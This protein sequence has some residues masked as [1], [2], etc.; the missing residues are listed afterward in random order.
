MKLRSYLAALVLAGV[1]PLVVLTVLVTISLARQQRAAVEQGLS[2]TVA[3]LA[4][5]IENEVETSIKSLETLATSKRLDEDDLQ[6]FYEQAARV[7]RLHRW[8]TIGLIDREGRHRLNLARPL[9]EPLPDLRD[10]D[11]FEQVMATGTP[12]VSDLLKGRATA[13]L[14]IAVAV[15]VVRDG[16]IKYVLFAGLDPASFNA[17]LEAQKLPARALASVVSRDG[18]F[19]AR[20]P[21][22]PRFVGHAPVAAYLARIREASD[23]HFRGPDLEGVE[24]EI[25]YRRMP[26]TGW[27]VGFGLPMEALNGP[28][29]RV[30]WTGAILGAAIV[31][32]ALGLAAVFA[33]RMA[34]SIAALASSASALGREEPLTTSARLPVAELD[35]MR[36]FLADADALLRA[37]TR[38][39]AELLAREQAARE[40]AE[41]AS[42]AK[43]QFLAMLGHELRNPLGAIVSAAALLDLV[44]TTDEVSVS[45]RQ[46][47]ARQARHLARL[48]DDLLDVA[49]VTAGKIIL[50]RVPV[51]LAALT[52]RVVTTLT[53][54]SPGRHVVET[55]LAEVWVHAD[56]TRIEQVVANLVGNAFKYTPP[57]ERISITVR[58]DRDEALLEVSD[59]GIGM[60]ADLVPRVF[61]LFVQAHGTPDRAR[62]GLGIGLTLSRHL[63]ALHNG[64][65][66][67]ASPG[68]RMG[69]TFTV[70]LPAV[71]TPDVAR[72]GR[73]A[74]TPSCTRRR[75]Q[76]IEDNA[77][78]RTAL[79]LLL[80]NLGHEVHEAAD[81]P[82]GLD[83]VRKLDPDVVL[84]D[85]GLPGVDG[86]EVARRVRAGGGRQP[87]LVALTGYGLPED[88]QRA[89]EAGFDAHLLKPV[90]PRRLTAIIEGARR[91]D[92]EARRSQ[93][94]T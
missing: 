63:V 35:E 69:S 30:A 92:V 1:L 27:T 78:S 73:I 52:H 62:G 79:S 6:A 88:R 12:Y 54:A 58:R 84:V 20:N 37:R 9:G 85:I 93:G 10:R 3:A 60:S 64:R 22:H 46:V 75:V 90:D 72:E 61:D 32:A 43:D 15:P 34:R 48:V 74:H 44:G 8:S 5:A 24:R 77:D 76:L 59:T 28:V 50:D 17:L 31:M 53:A 39:R 71:A 26:L 49:R 81:G 21:E 82:T 7:R 2:D 70:R 18:V 65:I 56:E 16:R 55:D 57:D 89:I 23:G 33:R 29:R 68:L 45:A 38:E 41:A 86:Y 47:I 94:V 67:A 66:T 91:T 14:D 25:A 87:L 80:Q 13:T 83:A 36:R 40:E 19:I 42:S 11:Y 4:S 51:N